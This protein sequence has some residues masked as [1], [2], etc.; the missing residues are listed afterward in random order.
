MHM[1]WRKQFST[2]SHVPPSRNRAQT[3]RRWRDL[4]PLESSAFHGALFA[5]QTD[6]LTPRDAQ[7]RSMHT[8]SRCHL[9]SCD[10]LQQNTRPQDLHRCPPRTSPTTTNLERRSQSDFR[11]E[12]ESDRSE[13]ALCCC[14][15]CRAR[16]ATNQCLNGD[17]ENPIF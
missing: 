6:H 17:E 11:V 7:P 16:A 5:S 3:G 10:A 1:N 15:H 9:F 12:A 13:L 14:E 4:R 2:L 8:V